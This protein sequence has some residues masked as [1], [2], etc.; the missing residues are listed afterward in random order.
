MHLHTYVVCW[1]FANF[2]TSER[3][4]RNRI[5]GYAGTSTRKNS[6]RPALEYGSGD[7]ER[8]DGCAGGHSRNTPYV[9]SGARHYGSLVR[10]IEAKRE[11]LAY[12]D[13]GVWTATQHRYHPQTHQH[14]RYE[15]D[16]PLIRATPSDHDRT[17]VITNAKKQLQSH[18]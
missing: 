8:N 14:V 17:C 10:R 18:P 12:R 5:L 7:S 1:N 3:D 13:P 11:G 6:S 9:M 2:W 15:A 16:A 4:C